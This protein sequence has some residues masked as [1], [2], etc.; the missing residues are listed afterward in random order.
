MSED[1]ISGLSINEKSCCSE[2]SRQNV[3]KQKVEIFLYKV[4]A[5]ANWNDP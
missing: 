2:V 3:L 4:K 1:R 5:A